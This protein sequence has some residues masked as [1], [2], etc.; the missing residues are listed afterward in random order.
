VFKDLLNRKGDLCTE[1]SYPYKARKD[2]TECSVI[3]DDCTR[4]SHTEVILHGM[5]PKTK[6]GLLLGLNLMPV[7]VAVNASAVSIKLIFL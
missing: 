6:Y 3:G 2:S 7:S 4:V 5:L 1:E